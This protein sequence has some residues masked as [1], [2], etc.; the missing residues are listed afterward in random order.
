MLRLVTRYK[1]RDLTC[2]YKVFSRDI[3]IIGKKL[4]IIWRPQFIGLFSIKCR[5]CRVYVCAV[6]SISNPVDAVGP[7]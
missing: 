4:R 3:I 1:P 6:I 7:V 5:S 2:G